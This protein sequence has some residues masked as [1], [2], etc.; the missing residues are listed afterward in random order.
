MAGIVVAAFYKF[1][2]LDD[3]LQLRAPLLDV[4]NRAGVKGTLLLAQEGINGTIAGT[5]EGIDRVLSYLM[6]D[7]RFA[8]LDRKESL[9]KEFPFY[10]MKVKLKK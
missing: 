7:E 8:D 6:K 2:T 9:D 3:Y 1:V 4:C 10:R 5:R